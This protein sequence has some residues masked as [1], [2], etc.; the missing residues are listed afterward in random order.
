MNAKTE[1]PQWHPASWQDKIASQQPMYPDGEA[2]ASV[3]ER[4]SALP[5]LVVS[6]EVEA[7]QDKIARAQRGEAFLLQ[8]GD[9]AENFADCNSDQIA[10]KLKILL[11]VS[12]VL[13]HSLKKPVIR[14]GRM[15]GQYAKPRSADNETRDG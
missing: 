12:V 6:W 8:G 4:L 1:R 14:V 5:P 11:Q 13:L 9:C 2:V 3:V 15:A 10:R 7:L